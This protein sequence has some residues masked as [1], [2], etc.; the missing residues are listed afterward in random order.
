MTQ[1]GFRDF[2]YKN[3]VIE[4]FFATES[5]FNYY[6]AF[7]V[8]IFASVIM[9]LKTFNRTRVLRSAKNFG[10]Y[11]LSGVSPMQQRRL[12]HVQWSLLIILVQYITKITVSNTCLAFCEE[13]RSV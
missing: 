10:L 12:Y 3:S 1:Q 6:L 11:S 9:Y 8:V 7:N 2:A 4:V 5:Y 13:F